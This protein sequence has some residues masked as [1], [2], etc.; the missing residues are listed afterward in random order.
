MGSSDGKQTSSAAQPRAAGKRRRDHGHLQRCNPR[1]R[2][3]AGL[4][5]RTYHRRKWLNSYVGFWRV[6]SCSIFRSSL[7][8]SPHIPVTGHRQMPSMELLADAAPVE[9]ISPASGSIQ[10]PRPADA[11]AANTLLADN[12]PGRITLGCTTFVA[13]LNR[14]DQMVE[15]Q[16]ASE[17][18]G[19]CLGLDEANLA[20]A[21]AS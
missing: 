3:P 19:L 18:D 2:R 11:W 15:R 5:R 4:H 21:F 9:A 20:E 17:N 16:R 13:E 12:V 14:W 1:Q 7:A 10:W 6:L 8:T